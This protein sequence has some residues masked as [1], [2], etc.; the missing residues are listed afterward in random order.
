MTVRARLTVIYALAMLATLSL[1]GVVVWWQLQS[2]LRMSLDQALESQASAALNA[3][4]NQGQVGLQEGD[5]ITHTGV[6]VV[7][8]DGTGAVIDATVGAPA[9]LRAP[10]AGPAMSDV[11]LGTTRYALHTVVSEGG[12]RVVAGSDLAALDATIARL[13]RSLAAVEGIALGLS[14]FGGWWLAGRALRPVAMITTEAGRI[15][16]AD[17]ER[18]LPVPKQRD[19]LHQLAVTLNGMLERVS[20]AMRRQR[21]F[22]A[23]ASHDLRT[24]ISALQAELDLAEDPHTTEPELRAAVRAAHADVVRLGE[25]AAAL[26]DLA[27]VDADGRALVRSPV[28]ADLLLQAVARRVEP[29]ARQRD[30]RIRQGSP[31]RL[32]RVDRIRIEQAVTNIVMNAI[33]YAPA[34][35]EVELTARVELVPEP[36]PSETTTLLIIEILDRG[37]GIPPDLA[38]SLFL[39]FH[40]GPDANAPGTGLGLATAAAAVRAHHGTIGF[41]QREGGGTR[42]WISVPA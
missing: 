9:D 21:M 34:G 17:V 22:V 7:I 28:M 13:A 20:E 38:D 29:L 23:A 25:L 2:A 26:L 36:R 37:P 11:V 5:G 41:D 14:L 10:R 3:I 6:F 1:A 40:R 12:L 32:I 24:P 27:A 31:A 30:I 18:R 8:F 39:P 35:S 42:F 33:A 16:A 4:E 19:E 15:G